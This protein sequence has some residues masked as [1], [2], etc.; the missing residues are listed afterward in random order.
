M[1]CFLSSN[2]CTAWKIMRSSDEPRTSSVKASV[3]ITTVGLKKKG[4][5]LC[6][7]VKDEFI[8]SC[9]LLYSS[10]SKIILSWLTSSTTPSTFYHA[11][12]H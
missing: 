8:I 3:I 9:G 5:K 7:L 11:G 4:D 1:S 12:T 6:N 2:K 10:R